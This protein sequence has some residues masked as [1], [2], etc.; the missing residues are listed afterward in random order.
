M[1]FK[2]LKLLA[3]RRWLHLLPDD[4]FENIR[5]RRLYNM[6][7]QG[8]VDKMLKLYSKEYARKAKPLNQRKK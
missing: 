8:M 7:W 5:Y 2:K 1:M 6:S 3:V 4:E